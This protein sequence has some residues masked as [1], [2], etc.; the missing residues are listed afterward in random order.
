MPNCKRACPH[1]RRPQFLNLRFLMYNVLIRRKLGNPK[2]GQRM[3]DR[4]KDVDAV[5]HSSSLLDFSNL[6]TI[7][8]INYDY[9]DQ[10]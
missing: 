10:L 6:T 8:M 4:M 7:I 5:F 3:K 1:L 2:M 9:R